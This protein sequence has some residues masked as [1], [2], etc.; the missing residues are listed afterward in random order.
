MA[1]IRRAAIMIITMI[2]MVVTHLLVII[3]LSM[4]IGH[5]G[6]VCLIVVLRPL[7]GGVSGGERAASG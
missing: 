7:R 6:I 1:I 4:I 3:R 2:I 5:T